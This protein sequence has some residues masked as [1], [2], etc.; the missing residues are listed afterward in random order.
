MTGPSEN[1][2]NIVGGAFGQMEAHLGP[3]A[4]QVNLDTTRSIGEY[5]RQQVVSMQENDIQQA[6]MA[7]AA[8]LLQNGKASFWFA[9]SLLVR[10]VLYIALF[11]SIPA[12]VMLW[13]AAL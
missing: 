1:F 7:E 11:M 12:M 13:R 10:T 3:E 5:N 8:A 6:R 9:M 2:E 4:Y